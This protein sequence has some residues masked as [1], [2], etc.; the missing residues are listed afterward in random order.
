MASKKK[1]PYLNF[2][3]E[4][5][6]GEIW[7]DIPFADGLYNLSNFGR[8]K[9]KEFERLI[10]NGQIRKFPQKILRAYVSKIK[11]NSIGDNNYFLSASIMCEGKKYKFS[12][13]R[14]VYYLFVRQ[15]P[16]EDMDLVVIAKDGDGKNIRPSNLKLVS[17]KEKQLRIYIRGRF[18]WNRETAMDEYIRTGKNYSSNPFCKQVSQYDVDGKYIATYPSSRVAAEI[19]DVSEAGINSVLKKRQVTSSGFAWSYK[20]VKKIDVAGIKK[21]NRERSAKL[22]GVCVSQYGF[23]G[24]L[25]ATYNSMNEA[26]RI[27][28][29]N[30]SDLFNACNGIQRSAGGFVWQKGPGK[31]KINLDGYLTGSAYRAIMQMKKVKLYSYSSKQIKIV[32]SVKAAAAYMGVT[33][34]YVSTAIKQGLHINGYQFEFLDKS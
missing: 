10:S 12:I 9:R 24:T 8:V 1:Y 3:F 26:S 32:E 31:D 34:S 18:I 25:L 2:D 30:R 14:L 15:F 27:T 19:L 4:N 17:I 16:M 23:N 11:N 7:D 33:S 20:K 22:R 13:A 6:K 21:A 28:G 5:L 29:I